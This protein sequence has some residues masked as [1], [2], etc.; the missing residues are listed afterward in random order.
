MAASTLDRLIDAATACADDIGAYFAGHGEEFEM[1]AS[2]MDRMRE[3]GLF[4]IMQ[5][6]AFGG[7][8]CDPETFLTVQRIVSRAS[9]SAGWLIGVLG[10][11]A[12]QLALYPPAAQAEVWGEGGDVLVA[13]SFMPAGRVEP[14]AGGFTISGTW[15]YSSG[16]TYAGWVMLGGLVHQD[17]T[18][19]DY[20]AFL[21]PRADV[22]IV[23]DW[24]AVGMRATGSHS[25]TV[26][27]AFVPAHRTFRAADGFQ[28]ACPGHEVHTNPIYRIPFGQLFGMAISV[29]AI[30]ALEGCVDACIAAEAALA[31]QPFQPPGAA[32]RQL[33]MAQAAATA[34]ECRIIVGANLA[35]LS[36]TA[37]EGRVPDFGE[38]VRM[39]YDAANAARKCVHAVNALFASNGTRSIMLD[40]RIAQAWL[41]INA[42][43]LHA[44]N[45]IERFGGNLGATLNGQAIAEPLL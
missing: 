9:M 31:A 18:A 33:A 34:H 28:C 15:R 40:N 23:P 32:A 22:A 6:A 11:Q 3:A 21:V 29:P 38:R 20:R 41:D 44:G 36:A 24:R 37:R 26:D 25:I 39:R 10:L 1:P 2:L 13:S 42:G 19:P 45:S 17:G 27:R 4:R 7:L 30:G 14:A 8:E 12:W 35:D 5:P 43:S 16:C